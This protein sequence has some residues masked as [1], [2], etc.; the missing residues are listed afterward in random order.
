[1]SAKILVTTPGGILEATAARVAVRAAAEVAAKATASVLAATAT[2][3]ALEV[4][5][6]ISEAEELQEAACLS[7]TQQA[8]DP[9]APTT[10]NSDIEL[11]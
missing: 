10:G 2:A 4:V 1:M 8:Q 9:L 3:T 6:K 7:T 11:N 5:T